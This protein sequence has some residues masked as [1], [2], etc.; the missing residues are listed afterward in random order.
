MGSCWPDGIAFLPSK[1][2]W[3]WFI[4]GSSDPQWPEWRTAVHAD[5][6]VGWGGW[7]VLAGF[8]GYRWGT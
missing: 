6:V 4:G 5:G 2:L 3:F 1:T 7:A 8:A